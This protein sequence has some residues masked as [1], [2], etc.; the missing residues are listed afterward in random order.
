MAKQL[1]S[2]ALLSITPAESYYGKEG[3]FITAD[4]M[5]VASA[6]ALP[7]AL[8]VQHQDSTAS[9]SV[10]VCSGGCPGTWEV[11]LS[12]SP[13]TVVRGT[14][15]MLT[16][17]GTVKAWDGS[18]TAMIVAEAQEAGT[19]DELIEAVLLKPHFSGPQTL[20]D[21]DGATLTAAQSGLILSNKGASAAAVFALPAALPGMEFTAI[22]EAA[23][24]LRL[25][26]NGAETI[27]LPS[28]GVQ[29]AA[30]KYIAADALGEK[31]KIAC[32]TAGTW[33]VVFYS[34]TWTAEA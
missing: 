8:I 14:K 18:T 4:L 12:A 6:L 9:A 1:R 30:G 31:A 15:L 20:V 23:F 24:E 13:G 3:F 17:N 10:A 5:L 19:A 21:V 22:V 29:Q 28:S 27:A 33:T 26:P 2:L 25:D 16:A 32:L 34:G 7:Y 11:K